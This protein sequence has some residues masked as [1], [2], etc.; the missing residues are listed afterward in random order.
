MNIGREILWFQ[1]ELKKLADKKR[2]EGEKR[3][4]KSRLRHYGVTMPKLHRL[5]RQWRKLHP[6]Q[7]VDEV[8]KLTE[9]LIDSDWYEEKFVAVELLVLHAEQ[10]TAKHLVTAEMFA[11]KV[12]TWALIDPLAIQVIGVLYSNFPELIFELEQMSRDENYWLR[13]IAVLAHVAQFRQ[14][15]GDLTNFEKIVV[16]MFQEEKNWTKEE[17]FFIRKAIG[18]SLRE[19]AAKDPQTVYDF[20]KKYQAHMSGLTYREAT[21]K[22]PERYRKGLV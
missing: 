2:A 7:K 17:R 8:V 18:W 6:Q 21:R 22:L 5:I 15:L 13:R 16:P 11:R 12:S 9:V 3:Y 1:A 10:L 19:L 14:G 20:I 4:L